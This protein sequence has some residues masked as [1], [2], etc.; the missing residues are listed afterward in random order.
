[1]KRSKVE[2]EAEGPPIKKVPRCSLTLDD[3]A[4]STLQSSRDTAS[5]IEINQ[6]LHD[7]MMAPIEAWRSNPV[8]ATPVTKMTTVLETMRA[9][10][11]SPERRLAM[12][13][14]ARTLG[15]A[16]TLASWLDILV[17]S[18]ERYP[19][20]SEEHTAVQSMKNYHHHSGYG[21]LHMRLVNSAEG[22]SEG[23]KGSPNPEWSIGISAWQPATRTFFKSETT[24]NLPEVVVEPPHRHPY[25]FASKIVRSSMIQSIYTP[26]CIQADTPAHTG[27]GRYKG[28]TFACVDGLWP[29][30]TRQD[31]IP[32]YLT[33]TEHRVQLNEGDAYFLPTG[34]VHD[35][36]IDLERNKTRPHVTCLISSESI[37]QNPESDVFMEQPMLDYHD[38]YPHLKKTMKP[39]T[40][41]VWRTSCQKLAAYLRGGDSLDLDL[42]DPEFSFF[43][44]GPGKVSGLQQPGIPSD[45]AT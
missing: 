37:M 28:I 1:M 11:D 7:A 38:K 16:E 30:H 43:L 8:G 21:H 31:R 17:D 26:E 40:S 29:P 27:E 35:V 3:E 20:G 19:E 25:A 12:V 41:K 23:T 33:A 6:G 24:L 9:I 4:I 18:D 45:L 10:S 2:T 39:M 13:T 14:A 34:L 32:H 42:P 44:Y 15:E 22:E 5:A 36:E